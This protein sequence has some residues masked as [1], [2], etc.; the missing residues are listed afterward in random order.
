M[1]DNSAK[2]FR[3]IFENSPVGLVL[4]NENTTLRDVNNYMFKSFHLTPN[5][6]EGKK[7]GNVFN[8]AVVSGKNHICGET[9]ECR[10]CRLGG[11]VTMVL[12]EGITIPDTVMDHSF[13][14]DGVDQKKW[15]KISAT[16]IDEDGDVFAIVSFV[17]ITTQ[18]DYEELL[19]NQLSLDMATGTTN[20][21][22]LLNTLK[23]LTA[24]KKALAVAMIDFDNFKDINDKYG[25]IT[26]DRVLN[27]FS[28]VAKANIR[29]QDILG[30]FGGEEFMLVFPDASS[31][32][33]IKAL[34]RIYKSFR[35]SCNKEL[36]ISPTFSAGITE[37]SAQQ[38]TE[39]NVDSI[40]SEADNNLYLSKSR[41]KNMI[42]AGGV[43]IPFK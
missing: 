3:A 38:M 31:G 35:E 43:S 11:G 36:S 20:K 30:R 15:F 27:I 9:E 29:K 26:G 2:M 19:N 28:A 14:I 1:L 10:D 21:Y 37:F 18:K 23:T 13:I 41:G 40:I 5:S 24:G 17:D 8:C 39:M 34:K 6:I 4:V 25:H 16:R 7:F 12:N 33:L 32:L 42:T 22:A